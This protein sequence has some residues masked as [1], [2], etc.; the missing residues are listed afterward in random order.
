ME[1]DLEEQWDAEDWANDP[2]VCSACGTPL[3][4]SERAKAREHCERCQDAA[5][6][7]DARLA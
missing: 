2:Y 1:P 7:H 4:R 3:T 5:Y 6:D